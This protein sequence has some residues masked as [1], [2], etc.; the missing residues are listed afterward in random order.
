MV[1]CDWIGSCGGGGWG[2]LL[3]GGVI[4]GDWVGWGFLGG[5]VGD[6]GGGGGGLLGGGGFGCVCGVLVRLLG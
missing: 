3:M 2:V 4:W 5:L 6:G 1:G